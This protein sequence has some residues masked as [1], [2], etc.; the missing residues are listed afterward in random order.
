MILW[1]KL[2]NIEGG[3]IIFACVYAS[4]IPTEKWHLWH[5][6]IDLLPKDCELIV[7]GDFSMTKIIQDKFNC[8]E[9]TI[10]EVKILTWNG[11]LNIFQLHDIFVYQGEPR[12]W[13]NNGQVGY[14]RR[15]ARLDRFYVPIHSS[16]CIRHV[17]Y[18][19]YE[20]RVSSDYAPVQLGSK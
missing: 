11:L 10:N 17:Q 7:G 19:I 8:C 14:V 15:L 12:F 16:L 9:R 4:N 2:E 3:N 13:W 20:Y 6:M 5:V 18:F 1:I